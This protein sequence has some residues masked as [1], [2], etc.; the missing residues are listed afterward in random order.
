MRPLHALNLSIRSSIKVWQTDRVAPKVETLE[1]EE[2]NSE[3]DGTQD[4]APIS[5]HLA[6]FN[7]DLREREALRERDSDS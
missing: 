2:D 6:A 5:K 3:C 4:Q 7:S 1:D